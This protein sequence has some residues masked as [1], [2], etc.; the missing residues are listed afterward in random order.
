M[1]KILAAGLLAIALIAASQQQASAWI[2]ARIGVGVNLGWQSGD[3]CF[4]WGAWHNGPY[5]GGSDYHHGHHHGVM[6]PPVYV[7]FIW[8]GH[9]QGHGHA[10]VPP[11]VAF[12]TF[13]MAPMQYPY[14]AP[15]APTYYYYYPAS[16]YYG[17]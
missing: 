1:K 11:P 5:P 16:Y 4:C 3:N 8:V 12:D 15:P 7:P 13:S 2:N 6:E 9:G 17:R 14:A 10:P